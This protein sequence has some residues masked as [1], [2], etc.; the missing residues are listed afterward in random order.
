MSD[1]K[2]PF[3]EHL[4]E[5]RTRVI[6]MLLAVA[7]GF[8]I[9]YGFSTHI[10]AFLKRPLPETLVFLSPTEAFFVNL[11]LAFFAGIILAV[12][13]ILL[14]C[15]R[16]V[17]PGLLKTEKQLTVPFVVS[18]TIL[19]LI[20]AGFCYVAVLPFGIK[21]LLGYATPDL[22]PMI[23]VS[24]YVTFV[25]RLMLAFGAVFEVPLIMVFLT[26]L[27]VVSSN[28]LARN[29]KY[30]ILLTFAIAAIL[31]PPDV[32]TQVLLGIPMILLY[33]ISIIASRRVERKK[34]AKKA[35]DLDDEVA[36]NA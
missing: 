22:K 10:L 7:V 5:L 34:A 20:G 26:K 17:A 11:K 19:F 6:R 3:T 15:W 23:S 4:V 14:Q 33:E 1:E 21:F 8:A 30:A 28:S 12:P 24:S 2:M 35:D 13:V 36:D 16:F 29:R 32:V 25:T 27:G 9:S 18:S 31:T